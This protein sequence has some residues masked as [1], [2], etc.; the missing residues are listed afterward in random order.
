MKAAKK[1]SFFSMTPVERERD[2]AAFDGSI[3]LDRHTKPLTKKQKMLHDKAEAKTGAKA[4]KVEIDQQLAVKARRHA[5]RHGLTM[6]QVIERGVRGV[7]A[8]DG[9]GK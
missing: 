3:D 4:F 7:L 1:K 5:E 6:R 9:E 8:F 2:V